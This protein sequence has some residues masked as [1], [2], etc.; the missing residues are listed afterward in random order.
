MD[1]FL[2]VGIA[3]AL[4]GILKGATGFG[5]PL[6]AVPLLALMFNLPFAITIFSI[7]NVLPNLWQSWTYRQH[8]LPLKFVASFAVAGGLGAGVG[9]Y[10]LARMS[11]D[12]LSLGLAV[13]I[14]AYVGF[15]LLR[16]S[17]KLGM[18][19]GNW[20]SFP[21]GLIAGILQGASGLSAPVSV[22]FLTSLHL[23]RGQ[24][25]ST[26]SMFFVS[27]GF[28]QIPMLIDYGYLTPTNILLSC[29]A[30]LPLAAGM[31]LGAMLAKRISRKRFNQILLVILSLLSVKLLMGALG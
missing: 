1:T 13:V 21:L 2:I 26:I 11:S 6:L 8:R 7:P 12:A 19:A 25:I 4:G 5:A 16:P 20:L 31:P 10:M 15:R 24:F 28:V 3:F 9:T 30:L 17:W 18:A 22:T 14:L 29:S 27:L 23:E